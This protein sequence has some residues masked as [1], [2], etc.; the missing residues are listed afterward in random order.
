MGTAFS[1][2][3]KVVEASLLNE[4]DIVDVKPLILLR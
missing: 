4:E 3:N 2:K 1:S